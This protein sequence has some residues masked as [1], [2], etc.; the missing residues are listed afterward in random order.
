ME[1]IIKNKIKGKSIIYSTNMDYDKFKQY[2]INIIVPQHTSIYHISDFK[3]YIKRS[4]EELTLMRKEIYKRM[5]A[6]GAFR[7][8]Y[9]KESIKTELF[10]FIHEDGTIEWGITYQDFQRKY[11]LYGISGLIHNRVEHIKGWTL[12]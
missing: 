9:K 2:F 4:N 12:L 6:N 3:I 5:R 11:N 7:N 10:D 8:P 1:L